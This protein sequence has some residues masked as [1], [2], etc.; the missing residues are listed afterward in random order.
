MK[1][2]KKLLKIFAIVTMIGLILIGCD[3]NKTTDLCANGHE[4]VWI[5]TS[6]PYPASSTE[7]CKNCNTLSGSDTRD[8]IVGDTGPAGGI[9]I[10]TA[11]NGF[12]VAGTNTTANYLEAA[13]DNATEKYISWASS[14]YFFTDVEGTGTA[15]GTGKNNTQ[16]ILEIYVTDITENYAAKA[17]SQYS[18][19]G[20]DDWFLPS[21][22][23]LNALYESNIIE[24]GS[25]WSSSQI[26]NS[27]AWS[28]FF[29]D[30][31]PSGYDKNTNCSVRAI[32]LF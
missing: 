16:K 31:D 5:V 2:T 21:K 11:V 15:I 20:K 28:Q 6:T 8:T 1:N 9:I 10:Y 26:N 23:E 19:G 13:P 30:G 3:I 22:D 7:M 17:C 12:P 18:N 27:S 4:F 32:R 25:F 29:R 14:S 24:T